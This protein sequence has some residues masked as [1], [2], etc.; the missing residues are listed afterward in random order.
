M[1]VVNLK[2]AQ[3]LGTVII[4]DEF[5]FLEILNEYV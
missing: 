2:K 4:L 5:K 3:D 1:L